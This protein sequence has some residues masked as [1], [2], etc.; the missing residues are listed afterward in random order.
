[1]IT[2]VH[3]DNIPP[4][5]AQFFFMLAL[6]AFSVSWLIGTYRVTAWSERIEE[7]I[8]TITDRLEYLLPDSTSDTTVYK[9]EE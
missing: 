8:Q 7:N 9:E 6:L 2:K 5:L 4:Q 3:V 1:M